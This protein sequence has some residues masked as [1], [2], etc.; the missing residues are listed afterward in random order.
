MPYNVPKNHIGACVKCS[1]IGLPPAV[2]SGGARTG[3][4]FEPNEWMSGVLSVSTG[5]ATGSPT[6]ISA[7]YGLETRYNDGTTPTAWVALKDINGNAVSVT[8][9]AASKGGEVDFDLQHVPEGHNEMR[10]TGAVTLTA[11]TSPTLATQAMVILG[12]ANRLPV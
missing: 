3:P 2:S 7:V 11:G 6:A 8:L 4:T 12:G 9:T 1:T 10:V 5:A